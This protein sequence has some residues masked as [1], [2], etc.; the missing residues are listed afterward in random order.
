MHEA[1][2]FSALVIGNS[3]QVN[4][5]FDIAHSFKDLDFP[6]DFGIPDW[7]IRIEGRKYL[8]WVL[9]C[10]RKHHSQYWC[11]W[12]HHCICHAQSSPLSRGFSLACCWVI[13]KRTLLQSRSFSI[14]SSLHPFRRR[15]SCSPSFPYY[16]FNFYI[17]IL[18]DLFHILYLSHILMWTIKLFCFNHGI[19]DP[20]SRGLFSRNC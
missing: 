1:V 14:S 16:S 9:W 12:K 18:L 10:R 6:F 8:A 5:M 19:N 11:I 3:M 2:S 17:Y 4:Y 20:A 13:G 7:I 15:L